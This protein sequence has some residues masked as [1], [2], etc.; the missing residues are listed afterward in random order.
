MGTAAAAPK[1]NKTNK[2]PKPQPSPAEIRAALGLPDS[3]TDAEVRAES[4]IQRF[5]TV[6]KRRTDKALAE[7][8]NLT[9]CANRGN[10]TY[11]DEQI[12]TIVEALYAE[13]AKV[14]AAFKSTAGAD[15]PAVEL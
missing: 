8:H 2:T 15:K 6:A 11:T 12:S 7:M 10:Y 4:K 1:T 13:V 9:R 14:E 5:K 3:A